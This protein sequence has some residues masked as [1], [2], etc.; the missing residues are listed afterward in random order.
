MESEKWAGYYPNYGMY[1]RSNRHQ[2]A[3]L[4][5]GDWISGPVPQSVTADQLRDSSSVKMDF[6]D[7]P[8]NHHAKIARQ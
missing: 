4:H 7:A 6:H 1:Y 8:A 3:Y 5:G 2:Y